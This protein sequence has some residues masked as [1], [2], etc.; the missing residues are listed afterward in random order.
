MWSSDVLGLSAR[1]VEVR[2]AW[3]SNIRLA[4]TFAFVFVYSLTEFKTYNSPVQP[5]GISNNV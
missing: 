1:I 3:Y 5:G 2:H 4:G